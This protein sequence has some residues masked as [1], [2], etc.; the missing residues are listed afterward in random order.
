M[1]WLSIYFGIYSSLFLVA[2]VDPMV[3]FCCAVPVD[4]VM[5]APPE[6]TT[7]G[8]R[9][10]KLFSQQL[11]SEHTDCFPTK[12]RQ[13]FWLATRVRVQFSKKNLQLVLERKAE[14]GI[15]DPFFFPVVFK[16]W[17]LI[18]LVESICVRLCLLRSLIS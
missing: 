15:V 11:V 2:S 12:R 9:T 5:G 10:Y 7:I 6:F 4:P 8:I 13:D 1:Y 16:I 14:R 17:C 3:Y 18:F